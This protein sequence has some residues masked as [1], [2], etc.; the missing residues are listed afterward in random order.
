[1]RFGSDP[2]SP[3]FTVVGVVRDVSQG[4]ARSATR[5]QT[6]VPY[7]QVPELAGGVS[8]VVKTNIPPEQVIRS[9]KDAVRAI[10]PD[11]TVARAAP[12]STLV[13]DSIAVPR[14]L[15]FI[16]GSFEIM[17][18]VIASIGVYGMIS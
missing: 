10:D 18:V 12:M 7:T 5:L 3:W 1:M 15:A 14:F 13:A 9:L 11:V 17:D 8:L 4:G 6:I 16:V 2:G